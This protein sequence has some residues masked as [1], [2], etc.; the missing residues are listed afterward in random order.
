MQQ[1]MLY[2][3]VPKKDVQYIP[4]TYLPSEKY[5]CTACVQHCL[6]VQSLQLAYTYIVTVILD[7]YILIIV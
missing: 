3:I 5:V 2:L 1:R 7:I 6:T 4:G